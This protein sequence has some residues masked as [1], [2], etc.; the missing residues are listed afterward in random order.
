[1]EKLFQIMRFNRDVFKSILKEYNLE[2]L[3]RIPEKFNNSLIWNIAHVLVTEQLLMYDLSGLPVRIEADM[4]ARFRKG[5]RPENDVTAGEIEKIQRWL[6]LVDQT[7]DDYLSGRFK[8]YTVYTTSTG[9]NIENIDDALRFNAFHE[10]IHLGVILS[11]K[12]LV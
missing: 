5:T 8:T 7:R 1:M 4:I 2:Q 12:K 3:N 11:L 10:G 9:F 6:Q